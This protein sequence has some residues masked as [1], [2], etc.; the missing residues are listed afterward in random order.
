MY[1]KG[2]PSLTTGQMQSTSTS[3]LITRKTKDTQ[4]RLGDAENRFLYTIRGHINHHK[5]LCGKTILTV[6]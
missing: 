3:Y 5:N 2:Q 4:L 1:V 6:F